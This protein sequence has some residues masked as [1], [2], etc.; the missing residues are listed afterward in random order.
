MD[1]L[2]RAL[3][4]SD[5]ATDRSARVASAQRVLERLG[6]P[7]PPKSA[8]ALLCALEHPDLSDQPAVWLRGLL[9]SARPG[10]AASCLVDLAIRYREHRHRGLDLGRAPSLSRVLGCSD[11]LARML[12]RHPNWAD[13]LIG[14]PP[15]APASEAIERD[16]TSIRIA[17]YKGLLRIAARDLSARPF[18]QSLVELSD[19]ADGCLQA[20]LGC[21]TREAETPAPTL[22]ALGK[23]GARELNFSSDVDLLFL[24]ESSANSP[25]GVDPSS[26]R[27]E[28]S[29]LVQIL[30]RQLEIPSEDGFGYRVD[31]DLRPEGRQG[32][33]V[34]SVDAA[35]AYYESF[36][37]EWERQ[38]LLRLRYVAGPE[39]EARRFCGQVE[40][41]LYRRG[42]DSS[43]IGRVREMKLKI[44]SERRAAGRDLDLELKEGPG[45]IRD[46]E[47]L[48][49]TLQLFHGGHHASV[50]GG[51]IPG[52][53]E[54][55]AR[56]R[57]LPEET[58]A[59]LREAYL[60]LRRA[61]H[62]VQLIEERQTHRFPKA[63]AAQLG[64]AR[65]MGYDEPDGH[66]A[67]ARLLADWERVRQQVRE[68]FA[69]LILEP[70]G[71]A[72]ALLQG[73]QR[74]GRT[75]HTQERPPRELHVDGDAAAQGQRGRSARSR[76]GPPHP[77]G[78]RRG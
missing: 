61:E 51:S 68:S 34:N 73:A 28:A 33:L 10:F 32:V 31:L 72:A 30:K 78:D 1:P 26:H 55:L 77:E 42:I 17:K 47:F 29:R 23:L 3:L 41:F 6:D 12:L 15:A 38:M 56:A 57:L 43:A 4:E 58:S 18:E 21:A 69:S 2:I 19:L 52:L 76:P 45:G 40:P 27:A 9:A 75:L 48:V 20:A 25:A 46:V 16:W 35:L 44:E 59:R 62:C 11:F 54:S 50:R 36:G 49:Q 63:A 22:L 53:L 67:R 7:E 65:R 74:P 37:A 24:H 5:S 71:R 13:E 8:A 64:L 39:A 70:S 66:A 14:D 60:W